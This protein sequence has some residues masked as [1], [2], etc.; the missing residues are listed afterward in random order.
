M[1]MRSIETENQLAKACVDLAEL[2]R[3]LPFVLTITEG[4]KIRTDGQNKRHWV[5]IDNLMAQINEAVNNVSENTGYTPLE[6]KRL[7]A[8]TMPPEHVGILYA[9]TSE[10]VHEILKSICS[11]PTSTR[12]GTKEFSKFDD[13]LEQTI[14][15]IIGDVNYM[16]REAG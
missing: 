1:K 4:K 15:H 2:S 9:R 8:G 11:I 12:L 16:A 10:V 3:C 13:I 5:N 14:A 6:V 7:I